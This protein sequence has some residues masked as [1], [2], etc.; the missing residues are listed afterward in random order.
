M[1][2][3]I[4]TEDI[5][6]DWNGSHFFYDNLEYSIP[7]SLSTSSVT[8]IEVKL[9]FSGNIS[10][11]NAYIIINSDHIIINGE[12]NMCTIENVTGYRGLIYNESYTTSIKNII[13]NSINSTLASSA[14]WVCRESTNYTT[15]TCCASFGSIAQS[16]GGIFGGNSANC[17]ADKC[18]SN[19][20]ISESAGGIFAANCQVSTA[21]NC[22]SSGFIN[23]YSGGIFGENA[24]NCDV[25]KSYTTGNIE[26]YAGGIFGRGSEDCS[27]IKSYTI[28]ELADNGN[29]FF[30]SDSSNSDIDEYSYSEESGV[31]NNSNALIL[32][33]DNTGTW[34][35]PSTDSPFVLLG[36]NKKLY[37]Q[38]ESTVLND[39]SIHPII[40]PDDAHI[41]YVND[42]S[43]D[44][45]SIGSN[46][47]ISYSNLIE[48][49]YNIVIY[50]IFD[51]GR[52][53]INVYILT[54]YNFCYN[55]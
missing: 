25:I 37:Y 32:T 34:L 38:L 55:L 23:Q 46:G 29:P 52:T 12:F 54:V 1:S 30:G 27:I 53:F 33:N 31:W 3:I 2:S 5:T 39:G 26:N 48:G 19:G 50:A 15:V 45:I 14:G 10:S 24:L 8:D 51:D 36:F 28:G 35:V 21:R 4:V 22:Y 40:Q 47:V 13:I 49:T 43:N 6:I 9:T 7:L 16:A 42:G 41:L 44:N 17:T 20:F 18:Y 11:S